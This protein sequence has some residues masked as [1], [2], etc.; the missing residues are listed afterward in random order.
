MRSPGGMQGVFANRPSTGAIDLDNV[1]PLCH[2]LDTAGVFARDAET[3]SSTIHA[4]YP[5]FTDY[6]RYPARIYYQNS[7][8][9]AKGTPAGSLLENFVQKVETF[10]GTKREY[11]DIASHWKDT[12]PKDTPSNVT[13]LLNT[14]I[15]SNLMFQAQDANPWQDICYSHFRWA[16]SLLGLTILCRLRRQERR[17]S[18]FHQPRSLEALAMGS[19]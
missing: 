8:F 5:N 17:P 14:V 16:I 18:T 9:P 3:W 1:L 2:D 4:W 11:V 12:H 7:S 10:L 19:K 15:E 13:D 6:K